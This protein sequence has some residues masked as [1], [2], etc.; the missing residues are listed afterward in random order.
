MK[1]G[2]WLIASLDMFQLCTVSQSVSRCYCD[3]LCDGPVME[4]F[5]FPQF[6]THWRA[7]RGIINYYYQTH[8]K[9]INQTDD[10]KLPSLNSSFVSVRSVDDLVHNAMTRHVTDKSCGGLLIDV[11]LD[12]YVVS[13][14]L[15]Y[16]CWSSWPYCNYNRRWPSLTSLR[17]NNHGAIFR[18]VSGQAHR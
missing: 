17:N 15:L 12:I 4:L 2:L 5:N 6:I 7:V 9:K 11:E 13:M 14:L 1:K 3:C 18:F 8:C 10:K 16:Y